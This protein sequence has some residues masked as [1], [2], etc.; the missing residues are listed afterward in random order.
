MNNGP[1][2]PAVYHITESPPK[3][4]VSASQQKPNDNIN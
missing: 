3:R 2:Q 1:A 4:Y